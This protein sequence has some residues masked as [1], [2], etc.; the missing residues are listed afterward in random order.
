MDRREMMQ[1]MLKMMME[2]MDMDV[3]GRL[4]IIGLPM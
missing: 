3:Q 2:Q 4:L 1:V